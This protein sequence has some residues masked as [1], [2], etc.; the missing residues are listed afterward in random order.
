MRHV[1]FSI[2]ETERD[3][4]LKHMRTALD[5]LELPAALDAQLWDY[6]VMA[7]HSLVNAVPEDGPDQGGRGGF[8][9]TPA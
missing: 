4:W 6:L 5:E 2:G 3:L 9:L 8:G 7:A 1:H